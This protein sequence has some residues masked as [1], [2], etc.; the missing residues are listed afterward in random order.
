MKVRDAL[1]TRRADMWVGILR[2]ECGMVLSQKARVFVLPR[3][4]HEQ[5]ALDLVEAF[6]NEDLTDPQWDRS[7][8]LVTMIDGN[9]LDLEYEYE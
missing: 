6:W 3:T 4:V 2:Q 5:D 7:K 8:I 1:Q 9:I